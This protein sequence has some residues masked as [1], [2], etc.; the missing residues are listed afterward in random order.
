M[1]MTPDRRQALKEKVSYWLKERI[2]RRVQYPE[3]VANA[4]LIKLA[5]GTWQ[6]QMDYSSLNKIC[7]KDMFPF[8]VEEEELVS[9]IGYRYKCFLRLLKDNSQIRMAKDDEDKTGFH[10]EE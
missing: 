10:I 4:K 3:W 6:V 7:A 2:I 5:N 9:L 1:T 8:L